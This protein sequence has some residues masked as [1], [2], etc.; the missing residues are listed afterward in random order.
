[1]Q[2]LRM[3]TRWLYFCRPLSVFTQAS[4]QAVCPSTATM[5]L[6]PCTGWSQALLVGCRLGPLTQLPPM[7]LILSSPPIPFLPAPCLPWACSVYYEYS[8]S[9][10]DGGRTGRNRTK[11]L[12]ALS[13]G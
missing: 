9:G 2:L 5:D 11:M 12:A 1:M 6:V 7:H 8:H 10:V 13:G 3:R 4:E